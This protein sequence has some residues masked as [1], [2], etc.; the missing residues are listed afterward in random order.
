MIKKYGIKIIILLFVAQL[1]YGQTPLKSLSLDKAYEL[2]ENRYPSLKDSEVLKEI[3]EKEQS[4]LNRNL[5]PEIYLKAEA[6]GQSETPSIDL[7]PGTA[8]PFEID[9]PLYSGKSYLELLYNVYDGGLNNAKR[10]VK[11]TQLKVDLQNVEVNRYALRERVNQLFVNMAILREQNK[12]FDISL[13]DLQERKKSVTAAA[14]EGLLLESEVAKI[15]VKELELKAE[16]DNIS[17]KLLGVTNTLSILLGVDLSESTNL[18]F[19]TF[20]DP[21]QIPNIKRPEQKLFQLKQEAVLANADLIDASRIPKLSAFAQGGIGYPNPL[22]F[23]DNNTANY[24]IIGL[25]FNWKI[26]DWGKGSLDNEVLELQARRLQNAHETFEFNLKTREAN[27]LAEFARLQ[28]QQTRDKEI[29]KLQAEI[30]EQLAFQF[31]EGIITSADY[32]TQVNAELKARQ[33]ILI[34]ET[35]LLKLQIDFWNERG[36]FNEN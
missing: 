31:D 26:Y 4:K 22:N 25:R 30:L 1:A 15:S 21:S 32:I 33:N 24:G 16:K 34:H 13:N 36:G 20:T 8:L 9:L 19:P 5:L 17:Y 11:E 18:K 3:H 23:F 35:L 14:E 28:K 27:Y 2:L 6:K 29:A 10:N 12:M 7:A